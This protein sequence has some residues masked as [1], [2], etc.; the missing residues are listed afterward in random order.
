MKQPHSPNFH[1]WLLAALLAL[2]LL[3][4]AAA[5]AEDPQRWLLVFSTSSAM[6]P[7]LPAVDKEIVQLIQ[8]DF[9]NALQMGDSLG[10]WTLDSKLH[11]GKFPLTTW[12][13]NDV[14]G[15]MTNIIRFIHKQSYTG[16]T[17]FAALQP[18]LNQVIAESQRL[19]I[20]L[21]TD[22]E[23]DIHWTP[24]DDG[25]NVTL[26]A[27]RADRQKKKLPYVLL[28]RTQMGKYVGASVNFPPVPCT[29]PSFPPLPYQLPATP[30]TPPPAP[31]VV[32]KPAPTAP[33]LIIVGSHVSS[34]TNDLEKYSNPGAESVSPAT[35]VTT[36]PV[37]EQT[38]PPAPQ[39]KVV[40][41]TPPTTT[42]N[43]PVPAPVVT[44]PAPVTTPAPAPTPTP[45]PAVATTP[46]P[47]PV[48]K[49]SPT[50]TPAPAPVTAP[51]PAPAPVA[52]AT[53]PSTPAPTP[54]PA[55]AVVTTNKLA[56]TTSTD[57][58]STRVLTLVGV[59]LFGAAVVLVIFLFARNRSGPESSLITKSMQ[60][61]WRPP[62][63]K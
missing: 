47:A 7:R 36:S 51:A 19:T 42:P 24:Y 25:I 38:P 55:P 13:P 45:T 30:T 37:V 52:V 11:M 20:I 50:P 22:G 28:F 29:V 43:P 6:K 3:P 49:S 48:T 15:T 21:V 56:A 2:I 53:P 18:T 23:D 16:T 33:P 26:K 4:A 9:G 39:P 59:S 31:V 10:V 8:G 46:P 14:P 44:A 41:P 60:G 40:T 63:Q 34:D 57:D 32:A 62:E 1:R 58:N 17:S 27:T 35:P 12:D 5:R 54:A 61:N